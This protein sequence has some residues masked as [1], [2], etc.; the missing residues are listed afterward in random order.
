VATNMPGNTGA[1]APTAPNSGGILSIA[2]AV[3]AQLADPETDTPE[4]E[5][6]TEGEDNAPEP[7][8]GGEDT[9][10][11]T[12]E[13]TDVDTEPEPQPD[14]DAPTEDETPEDDDF[15]ELAPENVLFRHEGA[16]VTLGE[17]E[18]GFLRQSDYTSKTSELAVERKAIAEERQETAREREHYSQS[19]EAMQATLDAASNQQIDWETLRSTDPVGYL[20]HKEAERERQDQQAKIRDEQTRLDAQAQQDH[21]VAR[22]AHE[23]TQTD[24]LSKALPSWGDEKVAT[25]EK[26]DIVGYLGDMGFSP[27]ETREVID[28]RLVLVLRDAV[29]GKSLRKGKAPNAKKLAKTRPMM[30]KAGTSKRGAK[31]E[32][33][34]KSQADARLSESGTMEDAV[35]LQMERLKEG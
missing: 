2:D 3:A 21:Q 10:E 14:T 29:A 28:H 30:K 12:P 13:D 20:Q 17:A 9:P 11:E 22:T 34:R 6:D 33:V 15:V 8:D 35:S 31:P 18:K 19:L 23:A 4:P 26:S 27:E 24:L 32:N 25:K 7:E 1:P 16:D 5:P